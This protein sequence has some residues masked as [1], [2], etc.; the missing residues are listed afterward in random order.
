MGPY[1]G[2]P[3]RMIV[4]VRRNDGTEMMAN[5]HVQGQVVGANS[6]IDYGYGQPVGE[7]QTGPGAGRHESQKPPNALSRPPGNMN[8]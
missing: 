3:G 5:T 1:G 6:P 2:S 7:S 4:V 8:H